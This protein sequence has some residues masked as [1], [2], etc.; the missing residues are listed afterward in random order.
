MTTLDETLQTGFRYFEVMAWFDSPDD[1]EEVTEAL[2]YAGYAFELTPHV[3]DE[4]DGI[5]LTPSVYGVISGYIE[6]GE[7]STVFHRLREIIRPFGDCDSCEFRD[8]PTSQAERYTRWTGKSAGP[9][10][11]AAPF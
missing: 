6:T 4:E 11:A 5:L 9:E 2:A 1:A 3:F 8:A 7:S 10:M